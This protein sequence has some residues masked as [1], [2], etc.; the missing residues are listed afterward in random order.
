LRRRREA[1][2]TFAKLIERLED[3]ILTGMGV[4][5]TPLTMVNGEKLVPLLDR[6]RENL[7]EE[8][9]AAQRVIEQRDAMMEEA[10][11]KA[12]QM[13]Q[14]AKRQA[15]YMLSESELLRAVHEEAGRVRVQITSELEALQKKAIE[16][17]DAVR[18]QAMEDATAIRAG[19]DQYADAILSNLDKSLV[20]FQAVVRNGQRYLKNARMEAVKQNLPLSMRQPQYPSLNPQQHAQQMQ[21]QPGPRESVPMPLSPASA[22]SYLPSDYVTTGSLHGHSRR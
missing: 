19:S 8:I 15:E 1:I 7:P 3:L 12:N 5:F 16:E 17:A 13:L 21:Q 20:E 10:Q 14:E 18:A 6:I 4:P 11:L 22:S 2:S 9:T